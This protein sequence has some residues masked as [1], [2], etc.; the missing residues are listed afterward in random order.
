MRR[1]RMFVTIAMVFLLVLACQ[2]ATAAPVIDDFGYWDLF[3]VYSLGNIGVSTN[4]YTSDFG[5]N[6]GAARQRPI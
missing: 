6:V 4:M 3:N 5:G 2:F 1:F